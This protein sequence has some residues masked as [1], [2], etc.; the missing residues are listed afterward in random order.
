[1]ERID[2]GREEWYV[3]CRACGAKWAGGSSRVPEH[4]PVRTR[5]P[6][7]KRPNIA[8]A[9]GVAEHLAALLS[10]LRIGSDD[11][12]VL[13]MDEFRLHHAGPL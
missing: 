3:I 7:A 8:G 9:Q 12:P 11:G 6:S 2:L 5:R 4:E 1:V 10:I 13:G